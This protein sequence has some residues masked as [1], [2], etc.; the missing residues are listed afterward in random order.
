MTHGFVLIPSVFPLIAHQSSGLGQ[1]GST[2]PAVVWSSLDIVLKGDEKQN[3][4][5]GV[6]FHAQPS[7]LD[8]DIERHSNCKAQLCSKFSLSFDLCYV[9]FS[10][11]F[12]NF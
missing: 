1:V 12:L 8:K 3:K 6:I 9:F 2:K 4:T 7:C 11:G 5:I 10:E